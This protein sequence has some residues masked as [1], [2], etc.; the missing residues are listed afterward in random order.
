MMK[1]KRYFL[2]LLL[3]TLT[4]SVPLVALVLEASY[5]PESPLYLELAPGIFSDQSVVGTKLGTFIIT[6]DGPFYNPSFLNTSEIG[7]GITMTGLYKDWEGGAYTTR[8]YLPFKV[9][10]VSYP[11]GYG[12]SPVIETLYGDKW[13]MIKQNNQWDGVTITA[14]PFYVE[15][16]LVNTNSDNGRRYDASLPANL[17]TDGRFFKLDTPYIINGSFS[18][19]FSIG[20]AVSPEIGVGTYAS[21]ANSTITDPTEGVYVSVEGITGPDSTPILNPSSFTAVPGDPGTPGFYYGDAPELPTFVFNFHTQQASF[22]LESA[23]SNQRSVVNQAKIEV[24]NGV[25]GTYYTQILTFNDNSPTNPEF[26]LLPLDGQGLPIS[27][28]LFLDT[29]HIIKGTPYTW[30]NLTYGSNSKDLI[31]GE[32]S[33]TEV[34]SRAS[35]IYQGTITVTITTPN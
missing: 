19:Y 27:Y 26:L 35:G 14:K 32:I 34:D 18:P 21:G 6:S 12:G 29:Q 9:L 33:Q 7:S 31:I 28:K 20:V 24:L 30:E 4:V 22:L 23:I 15:I 2:C 16:Y 5:V 8:T 1:R 11:T 3:I 25:S 10:S 13:P 17:G